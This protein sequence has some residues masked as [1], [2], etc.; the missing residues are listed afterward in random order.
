MFGSGYAVPSY[1][2]FVFKKIFLYKEMKQNQQTYRN[3][4]GS[5]FYQKTIL[6]LC[7]VLEFGK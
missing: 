7:S 2:Y 5:N 1:L 6:G 3:K 4:S